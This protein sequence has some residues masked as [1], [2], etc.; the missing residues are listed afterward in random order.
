[1]KYLFCILT[2]LLLTSCTSDNELH[3]L[4]SETESEQETDAAV[5]TY[6]H[7]DDRPAMNPGTTFMAFGKLRSMEE[8]IYYNNGGYM[9]YRINRQTGNVTTVCIDPLCLHNKESCPF[10]GFYPGAKYYA[11][12][13]TIHFT[14][15]Y[16]TPVEEF[17]KTVWQDIN[18]KVRFNIEEQQLSVVRDYIKEG[19]D[20]PRIVSELY[21]EDYYYYLKNLL[22]ENNSFYY[23]LCR[24]NLITGKTELIKELGTEAVS[25]LYADYERIIYTDGT[26][27]A[28]FRLDEPHTEY[29]LLKHPYQ[30]A[31]CDGQ[32][33]YCRVNEG[34]IHKVYC[35]DIESG[36]EICLVEKDT[37]YIFLTE[38]YLYYSPNHPLPY[39]QT[40]AVQNSNTIYR[41][42]KGTK[43]TECVF[44]LPE[45][46]DKKHF[47]ID[48]YFLVDGNYIYTTYE[49]ADIE[50]E[51]TL[52]SD[53]EPDVNIMRI[54][55]ETGEI[56]YI[57]YKE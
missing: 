47:I 8:Y 5:Y 45:D 51:T 9:V 17:G 15:R 46:L 24:D 6:T 28:Y 11:H 53:D 37:N 39:G 32:A 12:T 2:A 50:S 54:N 4:S 19:L 36:E 34:D 26:H 30:E 20:G 13:N 43:T 14:Q 57:T 40:K 16:K 55:A 33:I 21:Y 42:D 52:Q 7:S 48:R 18:R 29:D 44:T 27:V 38:K 3:Y 41:Y 1:M 10:W 31:A 56:T 23:Q 49:D 22:D 25:M 35:Y